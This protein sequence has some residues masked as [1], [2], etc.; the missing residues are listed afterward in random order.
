MQTQETL[1]FQ[2]GCFAHAPAIHSFGSSHVT[3][4]KTPARFR[5]EI[6]FSRPPVP[7][8]GSPRGL[9]INITRP[10]PVRLAR[11]P[12]DH[13]FAVLLMRTSYDIVD[14]LDICPMNEFQKMFFEIRQ[15]EWYQYANENPGMRQGQLT[16]VS[17][18]FEY[19]CPYVIRQGQVYFLEHARIHESKLV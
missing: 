8:E 3:T 11:R 7:S 19:T 5:C 18:G 16:D 9:W 12:L 2:F 10:K 1:M 14:D 17:F 13:D 4:R 6:D 15:R